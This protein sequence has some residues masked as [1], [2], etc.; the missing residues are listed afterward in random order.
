MGGRA[1][2]VRDAVRG[3]LDMITGGRAAEVTDEMLDMG[4]PVANAQLAEGLF[5]GY[6]LPMDTASRMAR[7]EAMGFRPPRFAP[8]YYHQTPQDVA[9]L[10]LY[11]NPESHTGGGAIWMADDPIDIPSAHNT[12]EVVDGVRQFR[13]GV[14]IM[15]VL[16]RAANPLPGAVRYEMK[17]RD[18]LPGS[19]PLVVDQRTNEAMRAAGYTHTDQGL[20]HVVFDPVNIRS[21]F[22]RFDPRLAHLRNLSAGAA[23]AGILGLTEQDVA[24]IEGYLARGN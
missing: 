18:E 12:S 24:D 7:A 17:M 4:D 3:L 15:P 5:R 11:A 20:E 19:F 10:R 9:A 16:T 21:R 2:A 1:T 14:N 6:D 22:A 8:S 23:G 13:T